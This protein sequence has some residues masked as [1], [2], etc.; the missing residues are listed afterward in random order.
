MGLQ[1]QRSGRD[2]YR[3]SWR[4]LLI[5]RCRFT[6]VS[7]IYPTTLRATGVGISGS[8]QRIG[9][10]VAPYILGVLVGAI[11]SVVLIFGFVGALMLA[12]GVIAWLTA[13]ETRQESLEQIQSDVITVV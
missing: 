7:E 2:S 5:W 11:V 12:C 3:R 13:I 4:V 1:P 10:I 9:G 8:W 6:Y